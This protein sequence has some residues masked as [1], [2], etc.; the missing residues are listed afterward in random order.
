[1]LTRL[2]ENQYAKRS[3]EEKCTVFIHGHNFRGYL[4]ISEVF[5]TCCSPDINSC[6]FYFPLLKRFD[7]PLLEAHH[8][9]IYLNKYPVITFSTPPEGAE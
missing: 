3:S 5:V 2:H 1:M 6:F 4:F 8:Y 7:D 9:R